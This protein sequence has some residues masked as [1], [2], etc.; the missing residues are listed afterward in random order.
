[1]EQEQIREYGR[2]QEDITSKLRH[3]FQYLI[4]PSFT[5]PVAWD[6]FRRPRQAHEDDYVLVRSSWRSDLDLEKLRTP[7]ERLRYPYPLTPTIEVHQLNVSSSDLAH[8]ASELAGLELAIGSPP[9]VGGVDGVGYEVA[10]EQPPHI[11]SAAKCRLSWWHKPPTEW[12][13]LASW[14]LRAETIFEPAW[15]ARGDALPTPHRINP[16]DDAAARH[17]AQSMF[18]AGHF[19]RVAELLAE[20]STREELTLAENKMLELALKRIRG[21]NSGGRHTS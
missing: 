20:V 8:L 4:L 2:L 5:P 6:V 16:I 12:S 7:V 15:S 1:M 13:A 17:E 19:G 11:A 3:V 9:S 10:I 18:H 21:P 14:V